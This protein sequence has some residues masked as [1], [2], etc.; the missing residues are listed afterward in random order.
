MKDNESELKGIGN[1]EDGIKLANH[2]A[3]KGRD[4]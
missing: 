4:L 3:Y 1:S 2:F